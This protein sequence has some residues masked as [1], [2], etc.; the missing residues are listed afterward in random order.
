MKNSPSETTPYVPNSSINLYGKHAKAVKNIPLGKSSKMTV[1][2]KKMGHSID[3]DGTQS[4][5]MEVIGMPSQ[6]KSKSF[7][8]Y[9][10]GKI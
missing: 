9:K 7:N 2:V 8:I 3:S 1:S 10:K 4:A 5:R 6:G